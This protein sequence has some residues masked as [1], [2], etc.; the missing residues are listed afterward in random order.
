MNY[1]GI[2]CIQNKINNKR[3][4]G[5]SVNI[6]KRWKNH[7]KNLLERKHHSP[8]LQ[9]AWNKYG[10]KNF[11]FLALEQVNDLNDL[12]IREQYYFDLHKPHIRGYNICPT[13]GS[14]LG[15]PTKPSTINKL[16]ILN[17]GE[18]HP[19]SKLTI[20]DVVDIREKYFQKIKNLR[21][22]GEQYGLD[23]RTIH[24]IVTGKRWAYAPGPISKP[25]KVLSKACQ[26]TIS[27]KKDDIDKIREEYRNGKSYG[28]LS[29]EF[30]VCRRTITDIIKNRIWNEK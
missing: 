13:A 23:F 11:I 30:K 4:I 16:E 5:S 19:K 29:Y 24:M 28:Q 6:E 8:A 27:L 22:L 10:E 2:Y 21:E 25:S 18:N 3:Y 9:N 17:R 1:A 15:R 12:L 14:C 7:R 20:D 26:T